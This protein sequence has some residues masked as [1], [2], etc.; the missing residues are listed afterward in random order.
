MR[1]IIIALC[2]FAA[3]S[4]HAA[5]FGDQTAYSAN[6]TIKDVVGAIVASPSQSGVCDSVTALLKFNFDSC[7]V[8][9]ALYAISGSDTV[10]VANGVTQ[11]RRFAANSSFAWH[12]FAFADPKPIVNAGTT[13]FIAVFA[14]TSGT[15]GSGIARGASTSGGGPLISRNA[16]Y[17]SG[18]PSPLNPTSGTITFK[19]SIYATYT[20]VSPNAPRRRIVASRPHPSS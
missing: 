18:M 17:E 7:K 8:R 16:N 9:C 13:Y 5:T 4:A 1:K 15:G 11:E 2:V 20:P 10:L 14:D 6:F 19:L 12:G 3:T